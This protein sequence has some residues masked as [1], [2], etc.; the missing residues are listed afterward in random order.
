MLGRPA[1]TG[2]RY[3]HDQR[4]DDQRYD[5]EHYDDEH[6]DDE[7]YDDGSPA[8][9]PG[10]GIAE[11][12]AHHRC[13]ER[14]ILCEEPGS[15]MPAGK[16]YRSGPDP[17]SEPQP[18]RRNAGGRRALRRHRPMGASD[19]WQRRALRHRMALPPPVDRENQGTTA[20]T[21]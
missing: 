16:L 11:L 19:R 2:T 4:Y 13:V 20:L 6:Y 5:D 1:R 7:H 14:R 17:Q 12:D 18:R 15:R 3:D 10:T 21:L 9:N 8:A